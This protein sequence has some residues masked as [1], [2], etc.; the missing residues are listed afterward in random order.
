[1]KCPS[2][3]EDNKDG[4]K[5]CKHCGASLKV[6]AQAPPASS[7]PKDNK[8]TLI[9]CATAII[10]VIIIAATLVFMN[11]ES[12]DSSVVVN[13]ANTVSSVDNSDSSSEDN[14]EDDAPK[15]KTLS[16]AA[17]YFSGALKTVVGHV[18]DECDDN[19][20]GY[21]DDAEYSNYK[22][23]VAFTKKWARDITNNDEVATPDLWNGDGSVRTRYCADHGRVAV[24]DD[25]RCPYCE[26]LGYDSRTRS[27]STSMYEFSNMISKN[28]SVLTNFYLFF[29]KVF[30]SWIFIIAF[31]TISHPIAFMLAYFSKYSFML[32]SSDMIFYFFLAFYHLFIFIQFYFP[33]I[34]NQSQA[35][36]KIILLLADFQ[37]FKY[38]S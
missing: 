27:G 36:P 19:G 34:L 7:Q 38:I 13:D 16:D 32:S 2:C 25:D 22:N 14:V 15:G 26:E 8:N 1:M 6:S 33:L 21:L 4:A 24:G 3:G 18:F 29:K 11:S 31:F 30:N 37:I 28:I 9:I 10:C 12:D 20:D 17:S 23:L 5:F 35:F